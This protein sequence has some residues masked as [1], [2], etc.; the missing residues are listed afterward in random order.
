[1]K[2]VPFSIIIIA[3]ILSFAACTPQ[4][5]I[6]PAAPGFN[7]EGSD[8]KAI[9]I[10]DA[11][12]AASGGRATWDS[13]QY[14]SWTFFGARKHTWNKST[15]DIVIDDMADSTKFVLNL[16]TMEGEVTV[17]GKVLGEL[18]SKAAYLKRGKDKWIN[19]SY[20]IF[21]P[22]KLKDSGVTLKYIG[23]GETSEGTKAD[24]IQL[25]FDN[26]GVTPD[27]KYH[28]YVD[29]ESSLV[30]QWDFFSSFADE[31]PRFSNPWNEYADYNGLMLSGG[32]GNR[33]I[34]DIKVGASLAEAFE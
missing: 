18:D 6:N 27:N 15:G 30:V 33:K 16:N 26:I 17:K 19:D 28:V 3:A 34:T 2:K 11:V 1:M 9:E 5:E 25:T 23:E 14:L 8:P 4:K 20:W 10:A 32:R 12:M 22:F 7:M 24:I 29:K 21:M 31:I 13:T